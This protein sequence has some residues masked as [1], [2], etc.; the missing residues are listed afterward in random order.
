MFP[1]MKDRWNIEYI[2]NIS[3]K[4]IQKMCYHRKIAYVKY[5]ISFKN[6]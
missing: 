2:K 6:I 1:N 3:L 5:D 4:Y